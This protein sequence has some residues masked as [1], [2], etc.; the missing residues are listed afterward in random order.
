M[1]AAEPFTPGNLVVLM[2]DGT[3]D[4]QWQA[5]SDSAGPVYLVEYTTILPCV[6]DECLG[7]CCHA[8]GTCSDN[9]PE[10][11]CDGVWG[12]VASTCE[13]RNCLGACCHGDGTCT[14]NVP[15][16]ACDGVWSRNAVCEEF[17]CLGACCHRDG[18]CSDNMPADACDGVWT[19]AGS[20]ES[21]ACLGACRHPD[22]T[23]TEDVAAQ[24]CDGVWGRGSTCAD[25]TATGACCH[26]DGTCTD[27]VYADACDG[28]WRGAGTSCLA[29]TCQTDPVVR[30]YPPVQTITL[31]TTVSGTNRRFT[32]P[33]GAAGVGQ[34]SLSSNGLFLVMAGYDAEVGTPEVVRTS[35]S[36]VNR[37]IGLVD[38]NGVFSTAAALT[39]CYHNGSKPVAEFRMAVT[40]DGSRFWM[41]G[42]DGDSSKDARTRFAVRG[43]TTSLSLDPGNKAPEP[44]AVNIHNG[45]L[46][47]SAWNNNSR[48][49]VVRFGFGL[50]EEPV[51]GPDM[52]L[53]IPSQPPGNSGVRP[54]DFWFQNDTTVYVADDRGK[55]SNPSSPWYGGAGKFIL[56]QDPE[57]PTYGT[58]V[59]QYTINAGLPTSSNDSILRSITGTTN[60]Q[61]QAVLYAIV[62][63]DGSG[64]NRLVTVTDTGCPSGTEP[65]CEAADTWITLQTAP[66]QMVFKGVEW[67]PRPCEGD[68]CRG[69]CCHPGNWCSNDTLYEECDG[70]WMGIGSTCESITCPNLCPRPFADSDLDG[71][72]DMD[73]FA[74][75][76]RCLSLGAAGITD[77]CGCFDRPKP[78]F[79]EGDG[80]VDREDLAAFLACASGPGILADPDCE[81]QPAE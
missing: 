45:Q 59:Y 25:L 19:R 38:A 69:A 35:A 37:V 34:L 79:P 60:E 33:P 63:G 14:D 7:A 40:D 42:K 2:A 24:D 76:Q 50:P 57:S 8:D 51:E 72:V 43:A 29:T 18:S 65:G 1:A 78:G 81:Q 17:N 47:I 53:V 28:A 58:W 39:D 6:G 5:Y 22:G 32:L 67:A 68:E 77:G 56:D 15:M 70:R 61:G 4:P 3:V 36:E 41:V 73:D 74:A 11:A 71:D 55:P 46:Y 30:E 31:P 10:S 49:G 64:R 62:A 80:V 16:S 66:S 75:W 20:C 48:R 52:P 44:L 9:V 13:N 21:Q 23:C 27:G 54:F 12:G 26:D